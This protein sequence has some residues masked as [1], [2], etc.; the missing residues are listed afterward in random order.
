MKIKLNIVQNRASA[1][2]GGDRKQD[3]GETVKLEVRRTTALLTFDVLAGDQKVA[4]IRE[5]VEGNKFIGHWIS[6]PYDYV[7]PKRALDIRLAEG[8]DMSIVS[9]TVIP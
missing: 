1:A 7:P 4:D 5:S 6:G 9:V 3:E 8:L 2:D